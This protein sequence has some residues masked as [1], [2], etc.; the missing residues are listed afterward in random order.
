VSADPAQ[1]MLDIQILIRYWS[2]QVPYFD[3][4]IISKSSFDSIRLNI[5]NLTKVAAN[6]TDGYT[7]IPNFRDKPSKSSKQRCCLQNAPI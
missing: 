3:E 2:Y 6:C 5:E 7:S 1:I 4:T